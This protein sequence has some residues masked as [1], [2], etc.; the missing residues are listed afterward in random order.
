MLKYLPFLLLGCAQHPTPIHGTG[1]EI[2]PPSG[3]LEY[4]KR[5]P[6]DR[7]CVPITQP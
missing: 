7:G 2:T 3:W 4:C 5:H 6:E 1:E